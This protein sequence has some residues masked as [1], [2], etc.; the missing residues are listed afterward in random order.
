MDI[1]NLQ[2]QS[3]NLQFGCCGRGRFLFLFI[4]L[5]FIINVSLNASTY[6][7]AHTYYEQ[8]IMHQENSGCDSSLIFLR[9]TLYLADSAK[10]EG[11]KAM[12][13]GQIARLNFDLKEF[14]SARHYFKKVLHIN[15]K[16]EC[17]SITSDYIGLSLT[18]LEQGFTDSALYYI[19]IG[20]Q[21]WKQNDDNRVSTSLENNTGRIYMDK[22]DFDHALKHFFLALENAQ[23][24]HDSINLMYIHL[25]IGTLYQRL[26]KFDNALDSYLK[27][28]EIS[29]L[30]KNTEGLALAYSI[31]IIY[32]ERQDYQTA[33]KYYT[34]ALPACIDLGKFADVANIYS[35]MSNVYMLQKRY[36]D[37]AIILRKSISLS[38]LRGNNRQLGIAY[39]N[40]GKTKELQGH[41]D[42]AIYYLDM[43]RAVFVELGMRNLESIALRMMSEAYESDHD[44]K[45]ALYYHK[46]YILL[47]DSIH[48][49]KVDKQI[50]ELQ[51]NYETEKKDKENSLLKKDIEFEK[52]KS[53]YLLLLALLLVFA[54]IV[55]FV[56]FYFIR[57]NTLTS[58]HL[59]ESKAASLV[60]K[61]EGQKREL[62]LGA[63]SLSR[64]LEF[65]NSIIGELKE[66]SDYVSEGGLRSLNNI[67]RKLGRQQ[68]EKSWKEF[69]KRFSDIHNDFYS[70]LIA[71]HPTLTQ[72]EVKLSA[73]LKLGMN[74]KEIC[75]ITFQ[76]VRAVEASRLR[77][78]KKL[79]ISSGENLSI[80]LLKY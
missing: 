16:L 77:L 47:A 36:P 1:S 19:T 27:S 23:L 10:D 54:G 14:D 69:E 45:N 52:G 3:A 63:L 67:V 51:L 78:R 76:S 53:Y 5:C 42:S 34:M 60:A 70:R 31:G 7:I 26:G 20:R 35:N 50:A 2:Y 74:T 56:L 41:Y 38:A 73:F 30:T 40:M 39:A 6:S 22:G 75:S 55:S 79:N 15:E 72:S 13:Y 33:L 62:T 66:L 4:P 28:L 8:A 12:I 29:R 57:K 58:K 61:L 59:A 44:Y 18:Y 32:K 21:F 24:N 43:S 64:N 37:A 65:I 9:Q 80:Y 49:E 68:S 71:D 11:S 46:E 48:S 17:Q 25:N